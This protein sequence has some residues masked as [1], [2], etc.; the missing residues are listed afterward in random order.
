MSS[1]Y[2]DLFDRYHEIATT[3]AGTRYELLAAMTCKTL[4]ERNVV[5]HDVKLRGVSKIK[6]Q[7][8]VQVKSL[9]GSRR[10]LIECKDYDKKIGLGIVR[11]F[12]SAKRDIGANEA[13]IVTCTG[14]TRDAL[15]FAKAKNIKPV[16]LRLFEEQDM[17]GRIERIYLNIHSQEPRQPIANLYIE[18]DQITVFEQAREAAGISDGMTPDDDA[19]FEMPNGTKDHFNDV[20]T[21][22]INE[23]MSLQTSGL[24]QC[25]FKP[26]G[27]KL[28]IGGS[29][30]PYLGIIID[31]M[32]ETESVTREL[33]S[34]RIAEVIVEGIGEADIIIFDDHLERRSIDQKTGEVS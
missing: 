28:L 1:T 6:H 30:V 12:E 25:I 11:D 20:L 22:A 26:Q 2:D 18:E 17:D 16:V 24:A 32:I 10:I 13:W 4:E 29:E 19:F 3:K 14:F 15:K 9:G 27:R 7:I 33:F 31:F 34:E 5:I 8:D 21:T 23:A